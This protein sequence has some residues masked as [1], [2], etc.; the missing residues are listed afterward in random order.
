MPTSVPH[1]YL[2]SIESYS[3][4]TVIPAKLNRM[5]LQIRACQSW[6]RCVQNKQ[7]PAVFS[8]LLLCA[9]FLEWDARTQLREYHI[10]DGFTAAKA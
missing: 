4:L 10:Q 1:I 9:I 7:L 6:K 3:Q 2:P 5:V 8:E